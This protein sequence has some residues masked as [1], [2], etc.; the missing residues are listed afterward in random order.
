MHR[1]YHDIISRINEPVKWFDENAVPRYDDFAPTRIAN[2]YS[3]ACC[4]LLIECQACGKEFRVAMSRDRFFLEWPDLVDDD[5]RLM[6]D[7]QTLSYGDPPNVECCP[8]GPTMSSETKRVIEF[9]Q[10]DRANGMPDWTRQPEFEVEVT[11]EEE[12]HN[13]HKG[14]SL[15]S[16]F[17]ELDEC[18]PVITSSH[19]CKLGT[20][21]CEIKHT[22]PKG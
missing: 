10:R 14:S 16:L 8:A 5:V 15:E 12:P 22:T 6:P 11:D 3:H 7:I 9:W 18:L 17:E 2:I 19:I 20:P 4:L 21:G 13:P 1:N